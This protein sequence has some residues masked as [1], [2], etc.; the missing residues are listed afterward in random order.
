M[1]SGFSIF[2]HSKIPCLCLIVVLFSAKVLAFNFKPPQIPMDP[3]KAFKIGEKIV[4]AAGGISDE[5]EIA[6]GR[7]VA[8]NLC[9]RYGVYENEKLARYLNLV[10]QALVRNCDRKNI[11]YRF[12]VL[13]SNTVNAFAAPGGYIFV[14]RG[15]LRL[16]KDESELAGVLAHEIAHISK[17][18]IVEEIR[19]SNLIGA[20]TDIINE[21]SKDKEMTKKLTEFSTDI[22][23]KGYSR[24]DEEEAD[25]L[26]VEYLKRTGYD[27]SGIKN[28][29]ETL[30]S[31]KPDEPKFLVLFKTHPHPTERL[32]T[33][34]S[35]GVMQSGAKNEK[36][37]KENVVVD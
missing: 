11:K 1:K 29:I 32:K 26:A 27:T 12:A 6:M 13:N 19:K 7:E 9:A 3:E 37:F 16:M 20:G 10:G 34:D 25:L 31:Q 14:T 17:R 24:K 15:A 5:E 21:I 23:F 30:S 8:S 4:K 33:I 28:F 22:L 18:H 35:K 2:S 36:R